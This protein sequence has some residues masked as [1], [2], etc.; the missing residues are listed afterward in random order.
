MGYTTGIKWD[1]DKVRQLIEVES[2]SGCKLLSNEY[3]NANTILKLQC[4][5]GNEFATAFTSF[6]YANKRQCND[7]GKILQNNQIKFTY[8]EVKSYIEDKGYELISKEYNKNTD[9]L[10]IKDNIGYYYTITFAGFKNIKY[11]AMPFHKSNLY[12]IQNIELWCK[13]NQKNFKLLSKEYKKNNIN[14]KWQCLK[15]GCKEIFEMSWICIH[16]GKGCNYCA[17]KKVGLS[18]CLATKNPQLASEW[19]P[20]K[21]NGLTP[22]DVTYG[23]HKEV[24]WKCSKNPKHEWPASVKSRN[25]GSG[26]PYCSG[27]YA[28]EDYN[29]LVINPDLAKEWNYNRNDKNPEEYCPSTKDIVWWICEKGHE[30]E[31]SINSRAYNKSNCCR[32]NES[33]G[34]KS[35]RKQLDIRKFIYKKEYNKLNIIG[36]G[37]GLLRFDFA[38]FSDVNYKN[39]LCLI[40]YDGK[41]HYEWIKG[42]LTKEQFETLQ[43]H[44]KLKDEY[45]MNNN[46][47]LLRIPYWDLEDIEEIL[48]NNL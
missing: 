29:L 13:I 42:W 7:C 28:S 34:E 27:F 4:K 1:I 10:T 46:I 19:H 40:E 24:W 16:S 41:Q 23:S 12:T 37:G 45:C 3:K 17:G 21:N 5:C 47:H 33:I 30:W 6:T 14:L 20:T 11:S 39:L 32:C 43:H 25:N 38:V 9:V 44:D 36:L 2:N 22:Y 15:E 48:N 31:A 18:N 35:I 8:E 26:C